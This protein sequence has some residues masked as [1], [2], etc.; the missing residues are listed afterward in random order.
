MTCFVHME[1]WN[2]LEQ[3]QEIK[4]AAR[5]RPYVARRE[6]GAARALTREIVSVGIPFGAQTPS[7][8]PRVRTR[9]SSGPLLNTWEKNDNNRGQSQCE[10]AYYSHPISAS[11]GRDTTT[12]MVDE[13]NTRRYKTHTTL[14]RW[15]RALKLLVT[16]GLFKTR[17]K[18]FK[19]VA[20]IKK[21]FLNVSNTL[22]IFKTR[23]KCL[24]LPCIRNALL[25]PEKN[26]IRGK[27][28]SP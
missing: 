1:G 25:I 11:G 16:I 21:P 4:L 13:D 17:F 3:R 26:T 18:C 6:S 8:R 28:Q 14:D 27:Y 12:Y 22:Q 7:I 23:F 5:F 9:D 19:R 15:L 20:N 2:E 10:T 24:A